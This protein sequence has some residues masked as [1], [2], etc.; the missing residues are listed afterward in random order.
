M[1]KKKNYYRE[2]NL[3]RE[4]LQALAAAGAEARVVALRAELQKLLRKFPALHAVS[5]NGVP[6]DA[7]PAADAPLLRSPAQEK[8][9]RKMAKIMRARWAN[10]HAAEGDAPKTTKP[11]R[12][13]WTAAQR[14]AIG[15]G[16][17]AYWAKKRAEKAAA[18]SEGKS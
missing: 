15:V 18:E 14:R 11:K 2:Q 13:V 7:P 5:D 1:A 6:A 4:E 8:K 12:K 10:L 9:A 17:K 16:I 3:T